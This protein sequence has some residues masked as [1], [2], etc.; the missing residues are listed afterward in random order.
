MAFGRSAVVVKVLIDGSPDPSFK[1]LRAWRSTGGRELDRAEI[2]LDL[3][4]ADQRLTDWSFYKVNRQVEIVA[5][6]PGLGDRVLHWGK[7]SIDG[8]KIAEGTERVVYTSRA[9]PYHFGAPIFGQWRFE[10]VFQQIVPAD[11]DLVFNPQIDGKIW[12]NMYPE[13]QGLNGKAS[14]VFVDPESLRTVPAQTLFGVEALVPAALGVGPQGGG[15]DFWTLPK[16]AFY[17]AAAANGSNFSFPTLDELGDVLDP[18]PD[19]LRDVR[20]RRGLYLPQSLEELLEPFGFGFNV[21]YDAV[22]QR[23]L[24]FFRR[25]QSAAP[26]A[27][28]MGRPAL[29]GPGNAITS[30]DNAPELDLEYNRGNV[31]NLLLVQG[32]FRY[33][34]ATFELVRA[35]PAELDGLDPTKDLAKDTDHYQNNPGY[36]DAWRKWALNES[37]DYI[38]LRPEILALTDLTDITGD[39]LSPK[40]RRFLPCI[41]QGADLAPIG[42][43]QGCVVE[44]SPDEG[45]TWLPPEQLDNH[46][47]HL[48]E[49][50]CGLRFDAQHVPTQLYDAGAKAKVRITATIRSDRR[51]AATA[52]QT[53]ASPQTDLAPAVVDAAGRFHYKLVSSQSKFYDQVGA[54]SIPSDSVDDTD[55]IA[56]YAQELHD[57]WDMADISGRI[58]IEGLD[59]A[60]YE[61]GDVISKVAGREISLDAAGPI[62]T[63]PRFPQVVGIEY[64]LRGGGQFRLLR[65]ETYR[66]KAIGRRDV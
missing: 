34:E 52:D 24:V 5:T 22:G 2:E 23:R 1:A 47:C 60:Q 3:A 48:L 26:A 65:L 39:R 62:V 12:P 59:R 11:E 51:L 37:G 28:T 38:G 58:K 7:L 53:D 29:S 15:A 33:F 43:I 25:G 18:D 63:E 19:L 55:A 16:A 61:L 27:V 4:A 6:I 31:R 30:A 13:L 21:K 45:A 41:T 36:Q 42:E 9:E 17:L 8:A 66:E 20:L 54:D 32:D 50:E 57:A 10:P 49:R 46:T 40:R 64:A 14:P 44:W 56:A 35:W